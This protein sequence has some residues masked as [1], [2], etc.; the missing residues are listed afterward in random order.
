MANVLKTRLLFAKVVSSD[1]SNALKVFA[2]K[3]VM[4]ERLTMYF[5]ENDAFY[6]EDPTKKCKEGDYVL[7]RELPPESRKKNITHTIEK[8]LY[9]Q[10]N[11]IDPLSGR[12]CAG[13]E[14]VDDIKRTCEL[15]G[16]ERP[17]QK[18]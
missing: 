10:G 3:Y 8:L 11:F 12:K 2:P 4:D 9:E 16:V 14:F 15:F 18:S 1:V 6:V 5:R 13:Q 7:V 17:Y